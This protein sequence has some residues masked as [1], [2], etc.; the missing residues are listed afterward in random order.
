MAMYKEHAK[1]NIFIALPI[2]LGAMYY[3]LHPVRDLMLTFSGAFVYSTLFMNPDLDLANQ[4]RLFSIRGFLT[5]P[6]RSYAKF[7]SHRGLSHNLLLGSFTR[8]AWLM[9]WGCLIFLVLYKT[10]P[11]KGTFLSFYKHYQPFILYGLAGICFADWGHLLLD[12]KKG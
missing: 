4:I 12:R 10:L 11:T 3:F 5:L 9:G 2:L 1:F 8:I 6:F 7:F